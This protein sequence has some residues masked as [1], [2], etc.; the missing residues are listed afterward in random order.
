MPIK[1]ICNQPGCNILIDYG[2]RYCSKHIKDY[3]ERQRQRHLEY[4][5][6]RNDKAEQAFYV[7]D[8]WIKTRDSI[9]V[10]YCG[11]CL[12]S[13]FILKQI[14]F[15]DTVHH[16]ITLKDDWDMRL[17]EDNLI[18]LSDGVHKQI[19]IWYRDRKSETQEVLRGLKRKWE[20]EY[21]K[22]L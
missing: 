2:Q 15:C 7:S 3:E 10:K 6:Y 20:N 14:V 19:H 16:I 1:K 4:K 22:I 9:K 18:S 13:L 11:L 17:D 21:E 12:Y 5:K 8:E